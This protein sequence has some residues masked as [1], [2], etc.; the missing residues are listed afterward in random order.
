VWPKPTTEQEKFVRQDWSDE[1]IAAEL[2]DDRE[3]RA[4]KVLEEVRVTSLS[5]G[6]S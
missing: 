2:V 4:T 5:W 1:R 6:S 3:Q